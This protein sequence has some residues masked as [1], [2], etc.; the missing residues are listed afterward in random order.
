LHLSRIALPPDLLEDSKKILTIGVRLLHA[1][2]DIIS[3]FGYL[4][5]LILTMQLCQMLVQAMWINDSPLLQIVE[6]P[7]A[8]NLAN[9]YNVKDI[10]DFS[11]MEQSERLEAIK[12]YDVDKIAEACNRYPTVSMSVE[13]KDVDE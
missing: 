2:V 4:K 9:S 3:S 8:E 11:N 12:G 7:C 1:L 13:L 5:P 10:N 6:R